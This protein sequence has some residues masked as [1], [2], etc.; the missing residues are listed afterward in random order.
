MLVPLKNYPKNITTKLPT[1]TAQ[2]TPLKTLPK[3][4]QKHTFCH[5]TFPQPLPPANPKHFRTYP[6]IFPQPHPLIAKPAVNPIYVTVYKK[7]TTIYIKGNYHLPFHKPFPAHFLP[8]TGTAQT[9]PIPNPRSKHHQAKPYLCLLYRPPGGTF[10][11]QET[12]SQ[13]QAIGNI[14]PKS[15]IQNSPIRNTT[16]YI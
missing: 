11:Y 16:Q 14:H 4:L 12:K 15:P 13:H 6:H 3:H 9:N 7:V 1:K 5:K 8:S 10:N 2:N